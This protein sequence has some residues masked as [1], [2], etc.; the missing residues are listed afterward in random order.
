M[1]AST[2]ICLFDLRPYDQRVAP[3]LRLYA[4]QYDPKAVVA[5]LRDVIGL[6]PVLRREPERML[7]GDEDYQHW[8]D[9]LQ[10]DAGNKPSEQTMREVADML[11]PPL[12]V[13]HGLGLNPM[14]E[15]DKLAPW[16]TERSDW[17]ADLE[18]GGEELAGGRLEFTFGSSSLIA[19]R[20]QIRQFLDEIR[21]IPPPDGKWS[22]LSRDFENLRQLLEKADSE[23][24]WTLLRTSLSR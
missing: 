23:P 11:I 14:Q 22:S 19:T 8:I 24:A 5:L 1:R 12:C 17:F 7:L 10:P 18:N 2:Y 3:A 4:R 16:L 21:G 20:P 15:T 9:S 13:P 6:L